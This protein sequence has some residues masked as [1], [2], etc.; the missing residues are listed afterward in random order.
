LSKRSEKGG[1]EKRGKLSGSLPNQ[2]N[3]GKKRREFASEELK[4]SI[5]VWKGE[6]GGEGHYEERGSSFMR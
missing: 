1:K 3:S 5:T 2:G 4:N 6:E